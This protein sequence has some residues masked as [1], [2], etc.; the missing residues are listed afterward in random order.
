MKKFNAASFK[1]I[2][3]GTIV[4]FTLIATGKDP[5]PVNKNLDV[6]HYTFHLELKDS[7]D[8]I[9]GKTEMLISLKNNITSF[10]IDLVGRKPDGTGMTVTSVEPKN[11]I[12]S[13]QQVSGDKVRIHLNSTSS[14]PIQLTIEYQGTPVDGLIIGKNKFGDRTF[15]GDNWPDRGHHWL[16]CVDHP[17]DKATVTFSV[18]TPL[19]YQVVATGGLKEESVIGTG[20]KLTRYEENVP[21]AVKVMTM[22]VARFA[23]KHTGPVQG[24]PTSIWVYPQNKEAGFSDFAPEGRIIRFF[25]DQVGPYSFSKLAH[26]QSKTRW[27]GL[28][29]AGNIFYFEN[30]VTGKGQIENLIAHETAHQWFGNSVTENDWHHVWLSE[31]FASYFTHLYNEWIYGV[32]KRKSG[33]SRDRNNILK[34]ELLPKSPVVDTTIQDIGKVLSIITYQKASFVLHMLRKE[35]GDQAFFSGVRNYYSTFRNGNALTIDFQ[36]AIEASS[37]KSLDWF[38]S[39]WIYKPGAP[40]LVVTW[41]YKPKEQEI[42]LKVRQSG[43][44]IFRLKLELGI[45]EEAIETL[46]ISQKEQVFTLKSLQ[47]PVNITLDP[48]INLLFSGKIAEG[49]L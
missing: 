19:H 31:G 43:P 34:H 4:F 25:M 49:K 37:G 45:G 24:T 44:D 12:K 18:T 40:D 36:K 15:F 14:A 6:L 3:T 46:E 20:K 21:V 8:V 11:L 35:V 47:K 29:N 39:Q 5:Y 17:S 42:K 9:F 7:T 27:G 41:E 23:V 13:F 32:E 10:E 16:A 33:M 26:V 28:E 38:F 2:V 22:G 48:A 30:S 1:L